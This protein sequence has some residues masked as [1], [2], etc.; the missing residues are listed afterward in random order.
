MKPAFGRS[1]LVVLWGCVFPLACNAISGLNGFSVDPSL[2]VAGAGGEGQLGGAGG[3]GGGDL[4][5]TTELTCPGET[6]AC[7][8]RT[9]VAGECQLVIEP[10]GKLVSG[11]TKG[12]CFRLECDGNGKVRS[13]VDTQ[14]V[15]DDGKQCTQD[16][17]ALD[18][19]FS[20]AS[21]PKGVACAQSGGQFCNGMGQC[22]ECN[23]DANCSGGSCVNGT[24][25]PPECTDKIRN[26]NESD[27]DC[28]GS[29]CPP[30]ATDYGC[31]ATSDCQSHVCVAGTC[32]APT[33][34]DVTMNGNETDVDCGGPMCP[35]CV[36][37]KKCLVAGDCAS[38][39]CT[40]G[41]CK[42]PTCTDGIKNGSETDVDC[43][44]KCPGCAVGL[45]CNASSDCT[46]EV[47][48]N[49]SCTSIVQIEAGTAHAC[50]LLGDGTVF[51]WGA[52]GGGQL[53]DGTTVAHPVPAIVPGLSGVTQIS[54]GAHI[55]S[56]TVNGHSCARTSDGKAYC[57]GRNANGQVGNGS[58]VDVLSPKVIVAADVAQVAAG[59]LHSCVRLVSGAV[60]CWGYNG[61]GQLGNGTTTNSMAP[62][63]SIA[64]LVAKN[65]AAGTTH[66]CA[67]LATGELSCWGAGSS[68]QLG[69][70]SVANSLV[71]SLVTGATNILSVDAGYAFTCSVDG[72][73]VLRCWGDNTFGELGLGS[74]TNQS[75]PQVVSTVTTAVGVSCGPYKDPGGHACAVRANGGL[76][77]SGN[78]LSGQLGVGDIVNRTTP[79]QVSLPPVAEVAAGQQFTCARLVNGPIRCWGRNDLAQLGTGQVTAMEMSPVPVVFP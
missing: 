10:D 8:T 68:G 6:N 37:D 14:D 58:L 19:T 78:N 72:G 54:L 51:C 70:G 11:Q 71:P 26:G 66:M 65:I 76:F 20:H 79:K 53:G 45:A 18:G 50:A 57:W 74:M 62:A 34:V 17:C 35:D 22:V 25:V 29:L 38:G 13:V 52:N 1:L 36:D 32:R 43:G 16:E 33:C 42:A 31:M 64:N 41:I 39:V 61:N 55:S 67:I 9:C 12:D 73:G 30:C 48:R 2:G 46:S 15:P 28:G 3:M 49:G 63:A 59:R 75:S 44:S 47:C 40:E 24:C 4:G 7:Q 21:A 77:C 56:F 5:C 69:N 27:I 60:Q 23:I